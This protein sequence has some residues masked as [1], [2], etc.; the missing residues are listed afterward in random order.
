MLASHTAAVSALTY[1]FIEE[2]CGA[3]PAEADFPNNRVVSFILSQQSRM[4]D[5]LRWPLICSTL[6]FDASPLLATGLCF[7]RLPHHR[8]WRQISAWKQSSLRVRRDL[9][10]FY[11]SLVIFAWYG[12]VNGC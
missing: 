2:C 11:E 10:K 3:L 7:H 1:S 8:R 12:E 9:M 5:Y 6:L 4:P